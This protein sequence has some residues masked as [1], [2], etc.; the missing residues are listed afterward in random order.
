MNSS[1]QTCLF[2]LRLVLALERRGTVTSAKLAED[3]LCLLEEYYSDLNPD[4]TIYNSVLNAYAKAAKETSDVSACFTSAQK[5]DQL[6]CKLLDREKST[7][8]SQPNEYSFL[9][10]IN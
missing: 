2:S 8:S 3:L 4:I 9:M 10:A 5:A 1:Q 6:L 7:M